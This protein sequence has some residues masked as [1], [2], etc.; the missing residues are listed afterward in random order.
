VEEKHGKGRV[1]VEVWEM[2]VV[3][4][5]VHA[6]R[7]DHE[8]LEAE[9]LGRLLEL[10]IK[11]QAQAHNWRAYLARSLY[12]AA[13]NFVRDKDLRESKMIPLKSDDP[14][15]GRPALADLLAAPEE[16]IDLR[17]DLARLREELSPQ[18]RDVWDLLMEAHG[19][20]SAVAKKLRRPRKSL[21]YWVGKLRQLSKNRA[22]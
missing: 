11:H 15:D 12:N 5:V 6:Y 21:D 18:L 10:K 1:Q 7:T 3:K 16:P 8:E 14:D 20:I 22:L 9:L 19:N 17:I 4:Q 13:K 2:E